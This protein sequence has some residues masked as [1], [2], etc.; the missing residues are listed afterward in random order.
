MYEPHFDENGKVVLPQPHEIEE[1][2]KE[3]AMGA[4]LMMFAAW[5]FGLPLPFLS[6]IA[7]V[8]YHVINRTTS[9]FVGFH[10]LQSL[11]TEIPISIINGGFVIWVFYLL[12]K[13]L[14]GSPGQVFGQFFFFVLFSVVVLNVLYIVLS[15]IGAVKSKKGQF[16]YFP[17]FGKI[18]FNAYYGKAA[19]SKK[20]K[21]LENKPP[22]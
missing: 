2:E 21:K 11:I 8:I 16:Y 9:R 15:V 7:A 13:L 10:S 4:Y 5:G 3:D 22:A 14:I 6:L 17:F 18:A 19:L 1:R 20:E 12:V